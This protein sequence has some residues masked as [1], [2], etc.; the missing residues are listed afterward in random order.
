MPTKYG[1]HKIVEKFFDVRSEIYAYRA[2]LCSEAAKFDYRQTKHALLANLE[3][4]ADEKILE[5][6]CGT[7]IW[8]KVVAEKC[9]KL[10]AIDISAGMLLAA[11]KYV[12]KKNVRF[13]KSDFLNYKTKERFDKIFAVRV[14]ESFSNK[15]LAIRKMRELLK[16]SGRL[17]IITK[18]T[19]SIWDVSPKIRRFF[20]GL[21][22]FKLR[23]ANMPHAYVRNISAG[24]LVRLLQKNGFSD[25]N[26]GFAV[27]RL[28]IFRKDD[29]EIPVIRKQLEKPA[30]KFFEMI[31]GFCE[32]L[33]APFKWIFYWLSESYVV[34]A[35]KMGT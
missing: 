29:R 14:L 22:P 8:T 26:F 24:W 34:C 19:P 7:G 30:L 11:K 16:P 31:S 3:Q 13:E 12:N 35:T 17:V 1:T 9:G 2:W 28:P 10:T 33:P 20:A 15:G 6:G 25:M 27:L 5:I 21:G 4:K 18:T 23:D 32:V